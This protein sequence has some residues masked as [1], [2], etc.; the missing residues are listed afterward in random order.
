[1][2]DETKPPEAILN[3][4]ISRIA[5][6]QRFVLEITVNPAGAKQLIDQIQ[7]ALATNA[8]TVVTSPR[9]ITIVRP[10]EASTPS[11][12]MAPITGTLN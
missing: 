1:M 6:T 11:T 5:E 12:A 3:Y 7:R 2:S 10:A 9:L 4:N 8:E